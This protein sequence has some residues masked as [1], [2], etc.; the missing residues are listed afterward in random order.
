MFYDAG[1]A[2]AFF[3][4]TVFPPHD[5]GQSVRVSNNSHDDVRAQVALRMRV[6]GRAGL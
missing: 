2:L 6:A 4:S 5:G 1:L 3:V